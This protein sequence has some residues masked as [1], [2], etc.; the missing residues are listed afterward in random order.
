MRVFSWEEKIMIVVRSWPHDGVMNQV[1]SFVS[2]L[3]QNLVWIVP[4]LILCFYK[5]GWWR[6]IPPVLLSSISIGLREVASRRIV[7]SL[8]MRPRPNFIESGCTMS[9]CWDS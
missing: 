1:M 5:L 7:K 2:D 3:R 4:V 9:S 8:V 6:V